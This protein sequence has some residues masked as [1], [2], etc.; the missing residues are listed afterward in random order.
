V[1]ATRVGDLDIVWDVAGPADGEPVLMINGLGA[2]RAGWSLQVP[3]L[4]ERYRVFTFDNRDVG[5][6]GAG[7]DPKPYGMAQFSHDSAGLI[8]ALELGPVHII[9]ASMGGAIAQELALERPDLVK[10]LQIVCSW[11]R[12]D[13]WLAEVIQQWNTIFAGL[14]NLAWARDTSVWVY[15]HRWF[16]DPDHLD[17][18]IRAAESYA[19][20]QSP[21]MFARQCDAVLGFD[22]L[23]RLRDIAIPTQVIVGAEDILTPPRFSEAIANRIPGAKLTVLPRVGHGM[24]W[25]TSNA[26]NASLFKFLVANPG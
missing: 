9:G 23:D 26:F 14:G 6:T 5:E 13:P 22:V 21:Q 18:L 8:D 17:E 1:P 4:A 20:S 10:S 11:P 12:T 15:T 3:A 25:E 19:F 7:S 24:F 2:P 16:L